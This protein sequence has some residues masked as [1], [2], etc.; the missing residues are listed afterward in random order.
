[1]LVLLMLVPSLAIAQTNIGIDYIQN[2]SEAIVNINGTSNRPVSISIKDDLRYYYIDQG[3]TD[4]SGKAEFRASLDTGK[5]YNCQVNIDGE[6]ATKK[7]VM[8]KTGITPDPETP[9]PNIPS[10]PGYA[11]IYIKGYK[12]VILSKTKVKI[13]RRD[14][15]LDLTKRILN[16][17]GIDYNIRGGYVAGI[18]G[19]EEFDKGSESG[20]MFS[21]NGKFPDVGAGSVDVRDGDFI[22]WLYTQDLGEDV[23][24]SMSGKGKQEIEKNIVNEEDVIKIAED[25]AKDFSSFIEKVKNQDDA[26]KAL[27]NLKDINKTFTKSLDKLKAEESFEKVAKESLKISKSTTKILEHLK[28]K[29]SIK[30]VCSL[31]SENN[32]ITLALTNKMKGEKDIA[33]IVE[34]MLD[35]SVE[36][37][38]K[39]LEKTSEEN[40]KMERIFV[41]K[42]P[43][44]DSNNVEFELNNILL[45]KGLERNISKLNLSS[46]LINIGLGLNDVDSTTRDQGIT[47]KGEKLKVSNMSE[48]VRDQIP[49]DSTIVNIVATRG[50][51]KPVEFKKPI[52]VGLPFEGKCKDTDGVSAFFVDKESI[53]PVGGIY[54]PADKKVY[55]FIDHFSKYFAKENVKTFKDTDKH[56]AKEQISVLSGKGVVNGRS[57]NSFE[58]NDDITRAEFTALIT[59]MLGYDK[60]FSGSITFTDVDKSQWYYESVAIAYNNGLVS[61]KSS[62]N[63]DPDGKITRQEMTKI[64]SNILKQKFDEEKNLSGLN[65][66][67]DNGKIAFWAKNAVAL[68]L[69]EKII[70]GVSENKFAPN[71]NATRA[72]AAIILYRLYSLLLEPEIL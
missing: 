8:K 31:A 1:M 35:S 30:E 69:R 7:L 44:V 49:Q 58:P 20:W 3:I 13:Y 21:V 47:I 55:F 48:T 22:K 43:Q 72:Q 14:S 40:K 33:K 32:G 65:K 71:D 68:S 19:Q 24:H 61:G 62:K 38:E 18:D 6:I 70:N 59:R 37:S 27:K 12:G 60:E 66:F 23:G 16:S 54:D 9:T 36:F 42:V 10:D 17:E 28:D 41:A 57:K 50:K 45:K 25:L 2:D 64:I 63:F 67:E 29:D 46:D 39:V 11:Y 52:K 34:D 5:T 51:G 4:D 56:W 15:V 26:K 53:K